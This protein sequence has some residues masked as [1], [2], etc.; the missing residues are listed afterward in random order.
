MR[1]ARDAHAVQ[2]ADP[3]TASGRMHPYH[4]SKAII[5]A[6]PD[7]VTYVLDGGENAPWASYHL[8]ARDAG[9]VLRI[10]Y[11][12]CLG[13]GQGYA[14]GAHAAKPRTT[15]LLTGDGAVGFN[16]Q[17]FETMVRHGIPIL[18]IVY[19]N[20]VWGM[21]IHGQEAVYGEDGVVIS[22][23]AD[24]DY[25]AVCEALGGYGERV[26]SLDDIPGAVQRAL[27]SG[28]PACLNL[29]IDPEV[30]HPTTTRLLG[31]VDNP[32]EIVV[33][34]YSNFPRR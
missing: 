1:R 31:D 33:P 14:L 20:T 22:R 12:G 34:Y 9:D 25:H 5:D 17:E 15:V 4:A 10:G 11:L 16:L 26:S 24:S 19:N 3:T 6:L 8:K 30:V 29:E 7:D 21:S 23:L 13:V 27:D 32:D 18:T 2:F 28:L